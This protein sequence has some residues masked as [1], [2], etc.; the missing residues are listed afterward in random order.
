M[1][2]A[3]PSTLKLPATTTLS[4]APPK[5]SVPIPSVTNES[6]NPVPVHFNNIFA[7]TVPVI[8]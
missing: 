4:L 6:A 8:N 2:E 7:V 5:L 3:V 1:N